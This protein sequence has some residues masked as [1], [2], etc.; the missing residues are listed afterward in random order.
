MKIT[1]RKVGMLLNTYMVFTDIHYLYVY[2]II[3]LLCISDYLH[4]KKVL[5]S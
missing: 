1:V 4:Y 2:Y 5:S 3:E